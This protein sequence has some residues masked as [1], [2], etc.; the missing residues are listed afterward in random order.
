M[1]N[2]WS[3]SADAWIAEMGERGD[4]SR[5]FVLDPA[6]RERL[7][8]RRFGR[9]LDVG[10]GEGRL[11][12][13]L[14]GEGIEAVGVDPTEALLAEARRRDPTGD[15]RLGRAEELAFEDESFD[16]VV[17]CLTLI[18]IDDISRAIPEMARVLRPGGSL[19]I[20]NLAN[21]FSAGLDTDL[22]WTIDEKGE[23]LA[24]RI[25]D[26]FRE[27]PIW[28]EW[29]GIRVRN[30]HRPLGAYFSLLLGAGLRLTHFSEPEPR[31]GGGDRM[32]NYMRM[33]YLVLM[34]WSKAAP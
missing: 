24:Y 13:L 28:A 26:Y 4:F 33:P 29:N 18:G 20:A 8:G 16:L 19:L 21:F 9:A 2:G 23:K 17:S 34:E 12:R 10:C 31:G 25:D 6:I 32:A 27:R 30:W 15:Y 7:C 1:T 11:C 22:G 5:E 3:E 14:A